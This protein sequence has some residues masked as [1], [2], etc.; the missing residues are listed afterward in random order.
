MQKNW[1]NAIV[2]LGLSQSRPVDKVKNYGFLYGIIMISI[3][4][5][6]LYK[7]QKNASCSQQQ[8]NLKRLIKAV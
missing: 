6:H 7:Q 1:L 2:S 8:L 3:T 4:G 5:G